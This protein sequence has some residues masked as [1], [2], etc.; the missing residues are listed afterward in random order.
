MIDSIDGTLIIVNVD[1]VLS[2]DLSVSTKRERLFVTPITL[3]Q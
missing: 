3:S 1:S 2:L